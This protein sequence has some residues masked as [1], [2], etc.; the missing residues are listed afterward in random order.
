MPK[1]CSAP[2]WCHGTTSGYGIPAG[3]VKL[4][5]FRPYPEEGQDK[6]CERYDEIMSPE[7]AKREGLRQGSL[8]YFRDT[9]GFVSLAAHFLKFYGEDRVRE[10]AQEEQTDADALLE[11]A[12]ALLN[13]KETA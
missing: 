9:S 7:E 11:K 12:S 13:E 3:M 8:V 5:A 6:Y 2:G 10:L 4:Q 1:T